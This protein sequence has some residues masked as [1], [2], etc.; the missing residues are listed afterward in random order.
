LGVDKGVDKGV[1]G[2][3]DAAIGVGEVG[4]GAGEGVLGVIMAAPVLA[5]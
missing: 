3:G 4:P 2:V 1:L 5:G